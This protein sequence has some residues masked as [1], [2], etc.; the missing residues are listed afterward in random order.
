MR[1]AQLSRLASALS[2]ASAGRS[3]C[4]APGVMVSAQRLAAARP[5]T[6]RSSSELLPRRL[7]PCT[8]TQAASPMA[9][10]G[11]HH[12]VGIAVAQAAPL[13][14]DSW[15][16]CRPCCSA[17]SAGSR[18][19]LR[20]D[21]DAGED[22]RAL[23]DAGQLLVDVLRVEMGQVAGGCG[24]CAR[25]RRGLRG[26]RWSSSAADHVARGQVLRVRRV[27]LHEALARAL[28]RMPPSP[29]TPSVI[30]QPAP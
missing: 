28:R 15:S 14:R 20:V 21:V 16:G 18:D 2:Q 30:R 23:G 9:P 22:P 12:R 10:S 6:T 8:E 3:F 26:S 5:N 7:A 13:R 27:A 29:R 25:R 4:A 24:P 1:V 19:R 17:R 11:R